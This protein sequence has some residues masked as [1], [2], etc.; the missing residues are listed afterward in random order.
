MAS[1]VRITVQLGEGEAVVF[2]NTADSP[3]LAHDRARDY[4]R[5][6]AIAYKRE[7][8]AELAAEAREKRKAVLREELETLERGG[9]V[10]PTQVIR[11]EPVRAEARAK[12]GE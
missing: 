10:P 7:W 12:G 11:P 3:L 8:H 9:T 4:L 2:E 6:S 1:L 5:E